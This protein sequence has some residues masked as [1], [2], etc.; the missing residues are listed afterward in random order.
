[1]TISPLLQATPAIQ[2]HV[3]AALLAFLLGPFVL[4][5]KRRDIWHK[6]MGYVW[7]VAMAITA[8]SSFAIA[9]LRVIGPYSPIHALSVYVLFGLW[10]N[11]S[12]ARAGR[13]TAH[14]IGMQ[15]MYVWALIVAGLFTFLPGRRMNAIVFGDAP[16]AGF[17]ALS[18][19]ASV[20]V[21]WMLSPRRTS[22]PS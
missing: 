14:R 19:L 12:A 21:L 22:A 7:V 2:I 8:L 11:I 3:F 10:Q 1:M 13:I 16:L 4:W 5:R 15:Q 17:L 9:D 18:A 20:A 6:R